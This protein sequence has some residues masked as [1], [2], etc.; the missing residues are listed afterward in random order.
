MHLE[1]AVR[2]CRRLC[3]IDTCPIVIILIVTPPI[4]HPAAPY[5]ITH[6]RSLH[7]HTVIPQRLSGQGQRLTFLIGC[8]GFL[9]LHIEGRTLVFLHPEGYIVITGLHRIQTIQALLGQYELGVRRAIVIGAQ[10]LVGYCLTLCV[11]EFQFYGPVSH[12]LGRDA[13]GILHG[14]RSHMDGLA[15]TVYTPVGKE[16]EELFT[17]YLTII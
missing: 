8:R 4:E 2:T 3:L 17:V 1:G 13:I 7:R 12:S 14:Y 15:R 9:N 16:I 5:Q 11:N 10:L 6:L